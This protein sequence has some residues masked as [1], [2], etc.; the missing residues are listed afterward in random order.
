METVESP[1]AN[2]IVACSLLSC[3]ALLLSSPIRKFF[4]SRGWSN[5]RI[6]FI[7]KSLRLLPIILFLILLIRYIIAHF[8]LDSS[9][10][11]VAFHLNSDSQ[12]SHRIMSLF[13]GYDG[14]SIM[15]MSILLATH[16]I[17]SFNPSII[18]IRNKDMVDR[19][20]SLLW[21]IC[22][23]GILP[24]QTFEI[25]NSN[26]F[27]PVSIDLLFMSAK[28]GMLSSMI[29]GI[30]LGFGPHAMEL[31]P[32]EKLTR[33]LLFT[34]GILGMV[35]ILFGPLESL[36]PLANNVWDVTIFSVPE[37]IRMSTIVTSLMIFCLVPIIIHYSENID[38]KIPA[39]KNRSTGLAVSILVGFISL[40]C[41]SFIL[42]S[43]EWSN[44]SIFYELLTELFPI[45]LFALIFSLLPIIGLDERSRPELHGWRYGLFVGLLIGSLNSSLISLS[46]LNGWIIAVFLSLTIPIIVESSPLLSAKLK[47]FN[48]VTS[49]IMCI[50]V[51]VSI[52]LFSDMHYVLPSLGIISIFLMEI[53]NSQL[54]KHIQPA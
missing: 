27:A 51:I 52:N 13:A 45:L 28:N 17:L 31:A 30:L 1:F 14:A 8:T 12:Y 18:I 22:L 25:I 20:F 35:S 46:L 33:P 23:T 21:I 3:F 32:S 40:T 50:S 36:T 49:I 48:V 34:I 29:F 4:I 38:S 24:E 43:P 54:P 26:E 39:G 19:W 16:L 47:M 2:V 7:G 37:I 6:I 41:F 53:N 42:L 15:L 11:H 10:V 44:A 5:N 9:H